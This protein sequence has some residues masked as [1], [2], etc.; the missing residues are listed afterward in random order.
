MFRSRYLLL[1][2]ILWNFD[3]FE[4]ST[5]SF[6]ALNCFLMSEIALAKAISK[7][8]VAA[9]PT[10]VHVRNQLGS[11]AFIAQL[12]FAS[13]SLTTYKFYH[14]VNPCSYNLKFVLL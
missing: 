10:Y 13:M 9:T 3:T 8:K 12:F 6:M 14:R 11:P 1:L 5:F 7:H 2:F 4:S